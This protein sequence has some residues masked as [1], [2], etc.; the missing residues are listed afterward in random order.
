MRG[1]YGKCI[2]NILPIYM[3]IQIY[4][5]IIIKKSV[6]MYVLQF[7]LHQK[8]QSTHFAFEQ[9]TKVLMT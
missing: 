1:I 4:I 3:H 6:C 5:Y 2:Y 8:H 7:D 9:Q